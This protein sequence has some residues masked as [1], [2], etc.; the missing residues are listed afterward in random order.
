MQISLGEAVSFLAFSFSVT[1]EITF[2][3]F[4]TTT[5]KTGVP[6]CGYPSLRSC[7][8]DVKD[9]GPRER[10]GH[11]ISGLESVADWRVKCVSSLST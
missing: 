6:P 10:S 5:S 9:P 8:S 7:L 11:Y 3:C 4:S 1:E 2:D